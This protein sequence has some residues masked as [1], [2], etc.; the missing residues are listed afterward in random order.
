MDSQSYYGGSLPYNPIMQTRFTQLSRRTRP[1]PTRDARDR[2]RL[3]VYIV[4]STW[5]PRMLRDK[6]HCAMSRSFPSPSGLRGRP[7]GWLPAGCHGLPG[8][9]DTDLKL[10]PVSCLNFTLYDLFTFSLEF[11]CQNA[12]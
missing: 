5:A 6:S 8:L 11:N 3:F 4:T 9:G 10:A 2:L 12:K 1:L 7:R